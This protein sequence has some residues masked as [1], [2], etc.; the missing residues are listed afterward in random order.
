AILIAI[1][2]IFIMVIAFQSS[3]ETKTF[4][5]PKAHSLQEVKQFQYQHVPG[6]KRAEALGLTKDYQ[7][8]RSIPGTNGSLR[9]EE[10]WYNPKQAYIFYSI[11]FLPVKQNHNDSSGPSRLPDL[12]FSVSLPQGMHSEAGLSTSNGIFYNGRLYRVAKAD[13]LSNTNVSQ[14]I[15][16]IVLRRLNVLIDGE[17]Y[18]LE[19]VKLPLN[20]EANPDMMQEI[21]LHQTYTV[22]D[23]RLTLDQ[24]IIGTSENKLTLHFEK[25]VENEVLEAIELTVQSG[26]NGKA[27]SLVNKSQEG[28]QYVFV[29]EPF[30][31][32]PEQVK[33]HIKGI[34]MMS[35]DYFRFGIDLTDLQKSDQALQVNRQL[36][37][38]KG[39]NIVLD[40]LKYDHNGLQVQIRYSPV[41]GEKPDDIKLTVTPPNFP[42]ENWTQDADRP[43]LLLITNEIDRYAFNGKSEAGPGSSYRFTLDSNYL[44]GLKRL[45]IAVQ[46]L[47]FLIHVDQSFTFSP[48]TDR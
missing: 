34:K 16:A 8:E 45:R 6:L 25:P 39:T 9:I 35:R 44:K 3:G 14:K 41:S 33:I 13:S 27:L 20:F 15:K 24:F 4:P 10:V 18:S 19:A 46:N 17:T 32:L 31:K 30:D 12:S 5:V 42:R 40:S 29:F 26:D 7:I 11:N 21:Q 22:Q 23:Y 1:V 37:R 48:A 2:F 36:A 43:L 38:K 28:N 47:P